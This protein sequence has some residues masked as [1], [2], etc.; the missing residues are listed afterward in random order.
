MMINERRDSIGMTS[1]RSLPI[2]KKR[3]D[4]KGEIFKPESKHKGIQFP[5]RLALSFCKSPRIHT[6]LV[7]SHKNSRLF[8]GYLT[9]M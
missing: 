4:I 9:S 3:V 8:S 1:M 6:N 2:E 5:V 7:F